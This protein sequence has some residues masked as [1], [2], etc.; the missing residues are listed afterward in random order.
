MKDND[1]HTQKNKT[2]II[3]TVVL[4]NKQNKNRGISALPRSQKA[5]KRKRKKMGCCWMVAKTTGQMRQKKHTHTHTK[6]QQQQKTQRVDNRV[7][8]H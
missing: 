4:L 6:Q 5:K 2:R 1:T 3:T 7:L 8:Q